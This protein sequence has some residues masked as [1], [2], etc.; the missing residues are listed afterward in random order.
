MT[1]IQKQLAD[2]LQHALMWTDDQYVHSIWRARAIEALAVHRQQEACKSLMWQPI[3]TAPKDGTLLLLWERCEDEPFIGSWWD[4]WGRWV[5]S[6]TH[7][8]TD[9]N[10]CVIDRVYSDGVT[11]WMPLPPTPDAAHGIKGE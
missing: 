7:Y 6:T 1:D 5:A 3:E 11:H 2:A 10:A 8:D 4:K 9:G